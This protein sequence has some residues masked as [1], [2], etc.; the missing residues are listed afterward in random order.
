[1]V[2]INTVG[3]RSLLGDVSRKDL[4]R[5]IAVAAAVV[6]L[7]LA[8]STGLTGL[9][10][11]FLRAAGLIAAGVVSLVVYLGRQETLDHEAYLEDQPD[12]LY[13]AEWFAG[14]S[15]A[16]IREGYVETLLRVQMYRGLAQRGAAQKFEGFEEACVR[17]DI[18]RDPLLAEAQDRLGDE[19]RPFEWLESDGE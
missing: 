7:V 13:P 11:Q 18:P 15:D 10:K 3:V 8:L 14:F 16:E 17:R 2:D 4:W 12:E 19:W 5:T 9:L 1:M 6:I